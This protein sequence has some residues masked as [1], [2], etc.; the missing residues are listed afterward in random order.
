MAAE[1]PLQF[2]LVNKKPKTRVAGQEK[3]VSCKPKVLLRG[4]ELWE[5]TLNGKEG[6]LQGNRGKGLTDQRK[7]GDS[8]QRLPTSERKS[9]GVNKATEKGI[10]LEERLEEEGK[11]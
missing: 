7:E 4:E 10:W 3:K 6:E 8:T 1:R 2:N 11:G 5:E 9:D